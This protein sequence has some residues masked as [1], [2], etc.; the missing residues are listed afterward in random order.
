M[1]GGHQSPRRVVEIGDVNLREA[2]TPGT[3]RRVVM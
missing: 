3:G 2:A 1:P